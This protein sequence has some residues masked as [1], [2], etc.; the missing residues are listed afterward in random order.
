MLF[1]FVGNMN[2]SPFTWTCNACKGLLD[3]ICTNACGS[4]SST[5]RDENTTLSYLLIVSLDVIMFI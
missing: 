5:R 4:I 1:L 3:I 2:K